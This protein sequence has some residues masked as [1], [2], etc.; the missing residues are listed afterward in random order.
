MGASPQQVALAWMLAMSPAVIPIPGST[1]PLTARE[2]AGAVDLVLSDDQL[3]RLDA[4]PDRSAR[5]LLHH[6]AVIM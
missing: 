5:T 1:R 3:A 4:P 2:S 6:P